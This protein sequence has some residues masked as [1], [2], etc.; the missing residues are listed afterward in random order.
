MDR[1]VICRILY[2]FVELIDFNLPG[3]AQLARIISLSDSIY[4]IFLQR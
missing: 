1:G 3:L 4:S 2:Y